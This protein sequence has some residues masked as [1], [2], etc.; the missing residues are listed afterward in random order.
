MGKS[1]SSGQYANSIFL[2]LLRSMFWELLQC[3]LRAFPSFPSPCLQPILPPN[4]D[5]A[6]PE[7]WEKVGE[8]ASVMQS[9]DIWQT[10]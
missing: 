2:L 8:I 3:L 5:E 6:P 4:H 9:F 1:T 10:Q 7:W